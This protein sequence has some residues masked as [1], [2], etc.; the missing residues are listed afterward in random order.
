MFTGE[1]LTSIVS[2]VRTSARQRSLPISQGGYPRESSAG[3]EPVMIPKF[4]VRQPYAGPTVSV[5]RP[6]ASKPGGL[7]GISN[8]VLTVSCGAAQNQDGARNINNEAT[9]A[10]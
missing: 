10:M 2:T 4:A 3:P 9:V 6:A 1:S 8:P 7:S 5:A